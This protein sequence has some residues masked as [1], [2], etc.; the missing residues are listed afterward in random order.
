MHTLWKRHEV[1]FYGRIGTE[2][3]F[4]IS[5]GTWNRLRRINNRP[6][7]AHSVSRRVGIGVEQARLLTGIREIEIPPVCFRPSITL[8][9]F[10]IRGAGRIRRRR[11]TWC[12]SQVLR[13]SEGPELQTTV[14]IINSALAPLISGF[15]VADLVAWF[16]RLYLRPRA[17]PLILF[18]SPRIPE[19]ARIARRST[20]GT[21]VRISICILFCRSLRLNL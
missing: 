3:P 8:R 21:T 18:Y 9:S 11:W 7:V 5:A 16:A 13:G 14:T 17:W 15:P 6:V 4:F 10:S 19:L 12:A 2:N 20:G 1:D